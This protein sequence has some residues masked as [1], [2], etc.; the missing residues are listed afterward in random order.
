MRPE[1]R[2][3]NSEQSAD[4]FSYLQCTPS[5]ANRYLYRYNKD[6]VE[7][8]NYIL[9]LFGSLIVLVL[10]GFVAGFSPTLY[11]A[12]ITVGTKSK[13]HLAF[14]AALMAGVL[15][16]IIVLLILFQTF[17]LSTMISII[18]K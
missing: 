12:Q 7:V 17:H 18:D 10:L 15:L 11:I 9:V 1:R 8:L 4:A 16:A 13:K 3:A 14:T 2:Q 6:M 5:N